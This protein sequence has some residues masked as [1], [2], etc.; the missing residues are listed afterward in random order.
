MPIAKWL[1]AYW[2]MVK[3]SSVMAELPEAYGRLYPAAPG[4]S[5]ASAPAAAFA[6]EE[7][8]ETPAGAEDAP[9]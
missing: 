4:G 6:P 5:A 9:G 3:R 2:E 7:G 1:S 8:A